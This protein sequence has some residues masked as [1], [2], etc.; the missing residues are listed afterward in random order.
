MNLAQLAYACHIYGRDTNYDGSY[1]R[2]LGA[3]EGAADLH[4]QLEVVS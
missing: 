4:R 2:F 3:T 1:V